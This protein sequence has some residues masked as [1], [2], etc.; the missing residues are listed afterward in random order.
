MALRWE[1][2]DYRGSQG[3]RPVKEFLDGL[4]AARRDR[5]AAYL[6]MLATEGNALRYPRSRHLG[7]G[8]FELRIMLADGPIRILY[9][10]QP[11]RRVLL[12]SAFA[13]RTQK[14]PPDELRLA[15]ARQPS[16]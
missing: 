16:A 7:Q 5:V 8:I 1:V 11:G 13:K 12:L 14:T 9:C 3:A 6:E 10:F 4:S 15:R 2:D